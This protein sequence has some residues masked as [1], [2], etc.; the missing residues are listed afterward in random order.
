MLLAATSFSEF[1]IVHFLSSGTTLLLH[2]L[3]LYRSTADA[4]PLEIRRCLG[5]VGVCPAEAGSLQ[6]A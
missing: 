5:L 6:M 4:L 1:S 3:P 2:P